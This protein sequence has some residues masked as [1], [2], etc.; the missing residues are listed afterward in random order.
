MA[1]QGDHTIVDDHTNVSGLDRR[2]PVQ[3]SQ[4]VVLQLNICFHES[5]FIDEHQIVITTPGAVHAHHFMKL[6]AGSPCA[7]STSVQREHR[8]CFNTYGSGASQSGAGTAGAL[9]RT[10]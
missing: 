7:G 8:D 3:F 1:C 2:I 10:E 6:A 4:D 9:V 5:S